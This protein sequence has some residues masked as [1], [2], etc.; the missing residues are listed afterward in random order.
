MSA[1]AVIIIR[2]KRIFVFLREQ[3]AVTPESAIPTWQVPHSDRWYFE[4]LVHYG[5]VKTVGNRC[6]L[7]EVRAEAYLKR[8]RKRGLIFTAL[9]VV[10]FGLFWLI[11]VWT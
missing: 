6:Y 1:A 8:W 5:A 7:D 3:G 2:I 10:A 4:R 9:A 11:W